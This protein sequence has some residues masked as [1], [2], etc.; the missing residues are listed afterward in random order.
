[1][2]AVNLITERF[3]SRVEFHCIGGVSGSGLR[4][5]TPIS[6]PASARTYPGFARW[7]VSCAEEYAIA[8]APLIES[9]FNHHKSY[10][11]YLDYGILGLAPILSDITPYRTVVSQDETGVLVSNTT[12]EWYLAMTR[13]IEEP[14]TRVRLARNAYLDVTSHHTL[15]AQA[16]ARRQLWS[17][18]LR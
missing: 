8:L 4:T 13:L 18:L 17:S 9:E 5:M 11:K 16:S 14:E 15:K 10:I 6:I 12:Q 3:G 2:D 7:L 1:L